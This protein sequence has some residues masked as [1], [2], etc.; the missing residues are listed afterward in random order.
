M[1]TNFLRPAKGRIIWEYASRCAAMFEQTESRKGKGDR[2][3]SIANE[4]SELPRSVTPGSST[5]VKTRIS[6]PES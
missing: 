6:Y 3:E 1:I 4:L 2:R 5:S